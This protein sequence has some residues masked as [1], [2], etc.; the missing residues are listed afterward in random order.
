ML[1]ERALIATLGIAATLSA[2]ELADPAGGEIDALT[3]EATASEL[4]ANNVDATTI[5][6]VLRFDTDTEMDVTFSTSSGRFP[7]GTGADRRTLVRRTN[8]RRTDALLQADDQA[9]LVVVKVSANNV[10]AFDTIRFTQVVP[11]R[12]TLKSN[13]SAAAANGN[14]TI[15][16]TAS[17]IMNDFL[18]R[19]TQQT[20][21]VF[22]AVDG[23]G[24]EVPDFERRGTSGADGT[25][26]VSLT[27][28]V[29]GSYSVIAH[30]EGG[31]A[32][33]IR[34]SFTG[35]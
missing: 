33:T 9:A 22:T 29:P 2:C 7:A 20:V 13:R 8:D 32:D 18:A 28:T 15:S 1:I 12:I 4:G 27:T 35:S 23:G 21:V 14:E 25:V 3:I 24:A 30:V 6:A 19:P 11:D 10:S 16:V 17:L 5:T 26:T 31:P 34:V